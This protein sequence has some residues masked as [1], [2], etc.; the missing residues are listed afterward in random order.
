MKLFALLC[1]LI[2]GSYRAD[3]RTIAILG[4]SISTGAV[5]HP[6]IS[7][8]PGKL[9]AVFS[10]ELSL[11]P[12]EGHK[13]AL[14]GSP[15]GDVL[16]GGPPRRL[17]FSQ[18]EFVG[19]MDW[20]LQHILFGLSALFLDVEEFSWGNLLGRRLGA[21]GEDILIAAQDGAR[22]ANTKRQYDRVLDAT[23]GKAPEDV[24]VFF[25]GNDLCGL[26]MDYVTSSQSY[27]ASLLDFLEYFQKSS[28][29]SGE[30][31]VWLL[32]PISS[33]QLT[34]SK[35]IAE[36]KVQAHGRTMS[37]RELHG[38]ESRSPVGDDVLL[39]F[40]P[41]T[42]TSYCPTVLRRKTP[43]DEERLSQLGSIV[44]GYREAIGRI[45]AGY[46][47]DPKPFR[48]LRLQ[49]PGKVVLEAD[50]IAEDCFHLSLN[51]Q[52]KLADAAYMSMKG[53]GLN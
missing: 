23:L 3:A 6:A 37:C 16:A 47:T 26:S 42:P 20:F 29:F 34:Y 49:D 52:I 43:E 7:Y 38:Y 12:T 50:D 15:Y 36:K 21:Q 5:S 44:S 17:S 19:G 18:R 46:Q 51:G 1:F 45:V 41:P 9:S 40:V 24:F 35:S 11:E 8:E 30:H 32:D 31:R 14:L 4:D 2:L 48:V 33:L 22:V 13:K 39:R 10:G 27:E 28:S 25:T 53:Q